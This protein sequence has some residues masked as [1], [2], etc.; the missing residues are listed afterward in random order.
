MEY[1]KKGTDNFVSETLFSTDRDNRRKTINGLTSGQN[2]TIRM[3]SISYNVESQDSVT[4]DATVGKL[5]HC[6]VFSIL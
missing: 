2:Y 3:F 4:V 6:P 5:F 1:T